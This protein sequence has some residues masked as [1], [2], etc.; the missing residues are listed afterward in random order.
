MRN[1][2]GK[3]CRENL[4]TN[5]I[6]SGFF[7]V[8]RKSLHLLD[9]VEKYG[10]AGQATDDNIIWRILIILFAFPRQQWLRESASML[11]L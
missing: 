4:D 8:F 2:S 9:N 3:I 5:F 6:Y 10:T 11:P 7:F 1:F